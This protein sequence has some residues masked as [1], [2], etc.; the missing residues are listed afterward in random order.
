MLRLGSLALEPPS[1]H[2][3]PS[4]KR[5]TSHNDHSVVVQEANGMDDGATEAATQTISAALWAPF[6]DRGVFCL[7]HSRQ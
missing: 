2:F 4:I 7:A 1:F 6:K 3:F 5:H